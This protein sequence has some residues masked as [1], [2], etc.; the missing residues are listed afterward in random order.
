MLKKKTQ[1]AY[2]KCIFSALA[3]LFFLAVLTV[4][5]NVW[6]NLAKGL[7]PFVF[8][9]VPFAVILLSVGLIFCLQQGIS[10]VFYSE[11]KGET[12]SFKTTLRFFSPKRFV[13]LMK[14][15]ASLGIIRLVLAL[16]VFLP[17]GVVF[18]TAFLFFKNG[19]PLPSTVIMWLSFGASLII[20]LRLYG[21]INS[22]LFLSKYCFFENERGRIKDI[23]EK[24]YKKS[25]GKGD[26]IRRLRQG[27]FLSFLSCVLLIPVP[28]VICNYK[29]ALSEKAYELM[30]NKSGQE[31]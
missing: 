11:R 24:S 18:I 29:S 31:R 23:I 5:P 14:F 17:V 12:V 1:S 21:E 3:V 27:F 13:R 28:F 26:G 8:K 16:A 7:N 20:S 2:V 4:F 19:S 6:D 30:K 15:Y 9:A 10:Y 22:L 25:K